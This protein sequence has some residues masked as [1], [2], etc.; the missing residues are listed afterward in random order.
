MD[1]Q[2]Y[3][4]A[5][6]VYA[7]SVYRVAYSY[8]YTKVDSEDVLQNVFLKL[9]QQCIEPLDRQSHYIEITSFYRLYTGK[10][11]PFLYAIGT[12]LIKWMKVFNIELYLFFCQRGKSDFCFRYETSLLGLG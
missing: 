4:K 6:D 7:D 11:N 12:S 5:V 2:D 10:T 9:F 8:T 1:L 3:T